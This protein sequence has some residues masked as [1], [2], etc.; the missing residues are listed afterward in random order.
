MLTVPQECYE[1]ACEKIRAHEFRAECMVCE[2]RGRDILPFLEAARL[3]RDRGA[4]VILKLHTKKSIHR[5]DG[6]AWRTE[7]FSKLLDPAV[8]DR[9]LAGFQ[10]NPRLG[11]VAP[12][13]SVVP[14]T[15]FWEHNEA[16]V[17]QLMRSMVGQEGGLHGETFVA[18]S[19]FYVRVDALRPL[20]DSDLG[21]KDF[22]PEAGQVDGT[23][24]HAIERCFMLVCDH[25]GYECVETG[26][27]LAPT[28]T[29]SAR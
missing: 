16:R 21:A 22:E 12:T 5:S 26:H 19:M 28:R 2:N 23:M 14:L 17:R 24:A 27:V 29:A 13:G 4:G 25:L 18:G 9:V 3:L 15:Y 6:N 11:L 20:L 7:L 8:V 10:A 1:A